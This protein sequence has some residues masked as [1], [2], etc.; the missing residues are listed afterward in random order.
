MFEPCV[1]VMT[2]TAKK[3]KAKKDDEEG[4]SKL[5]KRLL[6]KEGMIWEDLPKKDDKAISE[7][8]EGYKAFLTEGKGL[9]EVARLIVGAASDGGFKALTKTKGSKPGKRVYVVNRDKGVAMAILGKRPI[10]EGLRVVVSHIDAP[11]LDLKQ[12]PLYE[13]SSTKLALFKTHYYGGI[14]KYQW[15]SIPMALHGTVVLADGT[16]RD[17]AIGEDLGDPVLTIPDLLPHLW[18]Q[19]QAKRKTPDTVKGEELNLLVASRPVDDEKAKEKVKLAVLDYMNKKYGM[20]EE[21]F[22]SAEIEA[23]P[24]GPA[25]DVGLDRSMVGA[26]GQDDRV[27][28]YTSLQ[29]ILGVKTP[30]HTCIA[31]F[32]DKE[33]IGSDSN[34][35]VKSRFFQNFVGDLMALDDPKY[36]DSALRRALARSKC[37]SSDVNAGVNPNFKDV[38]EQQNAAFMGRGIVITKFTGAGGKFTANDASAEYVGEVRRMLNKA[39]V[40]WQ[41]G[42]LGKVDEGGG[43]TVAKFLAELDMDVIDAGTALISMHSPFEI[44]SK[45]DV[46]ATFRA[47]EEFYKLK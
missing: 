27:C 32:V 38:H 17:I 25:R 1:R 22:V 46:W 41:Y 33:E 16:S 3:G 10:E 21:D 23:V 18:R 24:A 11:R 43:G 6:F 44:S 2:M 13:D 47:F 45:A 37:L 34:T 26:Y 28:A 39:G 15:V 29:A 7:F 30:Q 20:V 12:K 4:E 14:K 8:S 31:L 36:P 40:P 5:E 9:R 42:A 35:G 19:S